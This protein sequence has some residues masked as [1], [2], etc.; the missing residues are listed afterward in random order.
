MAVGNVLIFILEFFSG[1]IQNAYA[2]TFSQATFGVNENKVGLKVSKRR[3]CI[4]QGINYSRFQNFG[5]PKAIFLNKLL[6]NI[7]QRRSPMMFQ[8]FLNNFLF[9]KYIHVTEIKGKWRGTNHDAHY[10]PHE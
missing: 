4:E 6:L 1:L 8:L 3:D 10:N 2:C 5:Y 9:S 7:L